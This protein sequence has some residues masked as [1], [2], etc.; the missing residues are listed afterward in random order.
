MVFPESKRESGRRDYE[1]GIL[2]SCVGPLVTWQVAA[3]SDPPYRGICSSRFSYPRWFLRIRFRR[4]LR[5][6]GL[7]SGQLQRLETGS[8]QHEGALPE[9]AEG[10][11]RD[12]SADGEPA[13]VR[14]GSLHGVWHQAETRGTVGHLLRRQDGA[15]FHRKSSGIQL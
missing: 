1:T 3:R 8:R 4:Q 15:Q 6:H 9:S 10:G 14:Q 12:E 5:P 2:C 11:E 7:E 13:T